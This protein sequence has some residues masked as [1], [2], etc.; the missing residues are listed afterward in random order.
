MSVAIESEV[1]SIVEP[2]VPQSREC[3]TTE[4]ISD[5]P[6][7]KTRGQTVLKYA[8]S[9]VGQSMIS[10]SRFLTS[11]LIGSFC[12]AAELGTYALGFSVLMGFHCIQLSLISRPYTIY[13]NQVEGREKREL[14]GSILVQFFIFGLL[15]TLSLAAIVATQYWLGWQSSLTPVFLT[16]AVGTPFILL[17][18]HARQFCFAQLNVRHAVIVDFT[19][20]AIH[21]AGL[22]WLAWS[23]RLSAV[24][25]LATTAVASGVAGMV[26]LWLDRRAI[27]IVSSRIL[28]DFR[29][30]WV[31]GKW[32]CASEITFTSQ[33]YG[34]TWLLA[35][36]LDNASVGIYSACM[37]S[38]QVLNPFLIGI[39]S[40][41]VPRTARRFS[42]EGV[43]GMHSLVRQT[44]VFLGGVTVFV[45]C[46]TA[47]WGPAALEFLYRGQGFDI[48]V[49]VVTALA[50]GVVFEV[51][52]IGPEN[53]LWAM[54]R[55]D[56]NFRAGV[57]GGIATLISAFTLIPAFGI[58]G[59][60]LSFLI[61][62]F[63]T[64]VAHWIAYRHATTRL[65]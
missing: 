10:G 41:L 33:F 47:I 14:A 63:V 6:G 61:G 22:G 8:G 52:G 13:G 23:G 35:L 48:P 53:G 54:E 62:Q 21:I 31:I 20:T 40:L 4:I 9:L 46:L 18:D 27:R 39:N 17:R 37:M 24:S 45:A 19:S 49:L 43:T 3:G 44:T 2:V 1:A 57:A 29:R 65:A 34:M 60:A 58:L 32:D 11:I 42:E 15:V 25:A 56:F 64:A 28:S 30:Q 16:L 38:I 12:G 36:T 26:W 7:R 50:C 59:A 55:H 5:D 51:V